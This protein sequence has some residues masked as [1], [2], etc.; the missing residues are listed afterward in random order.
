METPMNADKGLALTGMHRI[1]RLK[2][3]PRPGPGSFLRSFY[4]SHPVHPV[5]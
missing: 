2:E 1:E 4:P 3:K 5:K